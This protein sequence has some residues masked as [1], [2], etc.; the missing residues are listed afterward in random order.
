MDGRKGKKFAGTVHDKGDGAFAIRFASPIEFR[1]GESVVR[2]E[3]IDFQPFASNRPLYPFNIER[4]SPIDPQKAIAS[5]SDKV[6]VSGGMGKATKGA[7]SGKSAPR[8]GRKVHTRH[9]A[10]GK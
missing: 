6:V 2:L 4:D 7:A 5:W 10:K 1:R 9:R 8:A 3:A